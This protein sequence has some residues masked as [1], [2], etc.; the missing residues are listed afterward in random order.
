[1]ATIGTIMVYIMMGC[2]LAGCAAHL[3]KPES[4]LGN[5]FVDGISAIGPVFLQV[6]GIFAA[7]PVISSVTFRMRASR[8]AVR[9]P[10][11]S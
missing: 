4:E 5:K 8:A 9:S 11:A 2:L 3:I 1:M 10:T 6:G 7:L